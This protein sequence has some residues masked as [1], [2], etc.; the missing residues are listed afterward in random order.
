M[1]HSKR[2]HFTL[3][4]IV[5]FPFVCVCR[6]VVL[7]LFNHY[8]NVWLF[9][10][11]GTKYALFLFLLWIEKHLIE[12]WAKMSRANAFEHSLCCVLYIL[13]RFFGANIIRFVK[14]LW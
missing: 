8:G 9:R 3:C 11:L 5:F 10:L 13:S 12:I 6:F 14:Q 4:A 7:V 2:I 1:V